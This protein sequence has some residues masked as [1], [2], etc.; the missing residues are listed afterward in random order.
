[1]K[2]KTQKNAKKNSLLSHLAVR[3]VA[4]KPLVPVRDVE[5]A[6]KGSLERAEH[7]R[8]GRGPLEARVEQHR[9]RPRRAVGGLDGKVLARRLLQPGV[10]LGEAELAQRAAR[11]QQ[12]HRVGG[13]VVGQAHFEAVARELVRVGGDH[14]GV[15]RQRRGD[16]LADDVLGGEADD[17]AVLGGVEPGVW[18]G[19]WKGGEGRWRGGEVVSLNENGIIMK[20]H[21]FRIPAAGARAGRTGERSAPAKARRETIRTQSANTSR[22]GSPAQHDEA[23]GTLNCRRHRKNE[24]EETLSLVLVLGHEAQPRPVVGLALAAAAVLDLVPRE[25]GR[26]LDDLDVAHGW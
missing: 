7:A 26:R 13:R 6:V 9:E 5:P 8:A 21:L 4:D 10:G 25:V 15:S 24:K 2:K 12:A 22:A 18:R 23:I 3:V 11:D 20:H 16:D 1:M 19:G 17:E 14:H